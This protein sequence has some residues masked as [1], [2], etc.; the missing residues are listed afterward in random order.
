MGLR[1]P[2]PE[3]T[4]VK[5]GVCVECGWQPSVAYQNHSK[6]RGWLLGRAAL[7]MGDLSQR[8]ERSLGQQPD[9]TGI[10]ASQVEEGIYEPGKREA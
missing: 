10:P 8:E 5:E 3:P 4:W 6:V 7:V 9:V 2:G 1:T